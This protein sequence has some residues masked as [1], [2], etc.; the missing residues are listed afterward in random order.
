LQVADNVALPLLLLG[1]PDAQR[2]QAMLDAVGLAGLGAR[3]PAQLSGGQLQRVALARALVHR[4]ALILADEPTGNLDPPTAA[5]M[6]ALLA[7]QVRSHGAACL[8]VT[9]SQAAAAFADR[10]ARLTPEGI[11]DEAA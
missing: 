4:P 9:H 7:E 8:L 5:R 2:V 11:V 1:K 3:M 6:M 10:R